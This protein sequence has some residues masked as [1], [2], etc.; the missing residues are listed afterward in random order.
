ME[1]DLLEFT[2][3]PQAVPRPPLM[4][5]FRC[6][7]VR[8]TYSLSDLLLLHFETPLSIDTDGSAGRRWATMSV[9]FASFRLPYFQGSMHIY[10]FYPSKCGREARS[11]YGRRDCGSVAYVYADRKRR[12]QCGRSLG[13]DVGEIH[14]LYDV[15]TLGHADGPGIL[16]FVSEGLRWT[17]HTVEPIH[18]R[19]CL[20]LWT[21][22][23][24]HGGYTALM[25]HPAFRR[26]AR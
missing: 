19:H 8:S 14:L 9:E 16:E 2:H 13:L 7:S 3:A 24:T 10:P 12:C 20:S 5:K 6:Y 21:D 1:T 23:F 4:R 17:R 11:R 22:P 18:R 25:W 15:S 26:L